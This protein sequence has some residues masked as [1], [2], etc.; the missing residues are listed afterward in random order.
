[1]AELEAALE[2]KEEA[3]TA[4]LKEE[5]SEAERKRSV[6]CRRARIVDTA[7]R[8][9]R[10]RGALG[11]DQLASHRLKARQYRLANSAGF[12]EDD[13]VWPFRTSR[14]RVR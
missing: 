6:T 13:S 7:A 11:K 14:T 4:A 3:T 10:D 1:M 9:G 12:N 5:D 8:D 2:G